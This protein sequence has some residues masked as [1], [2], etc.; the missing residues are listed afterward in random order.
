MILADKFRQLLR[1]GELAYRT[2]GP[3]R[4]AEKKFRRSKL[5]NLNRSHRMV[6]DDE[7]ATL[8]HR[9]AMLDPASLLG[10]LNYARPPFDHL[11]VEYNRVARIREE[12]TVR[13][14]A[15]FIEPDTMYGGQWRLS[16]VVEAE[17]NSGR[18]MLMP[19]GFVVDFS[20]ADFIDGSTFEKLSYDHLSGNFMRSDMDDPENFMK[21]T[22]TV[23]G[24]SKGYIQ[25]WGK[26]EGKIGRNRAQLLARYTAP[27]IADE[28][29]IAMMAEN[30]QKAERLMAVGLDEVAGEVRFMIGVLALLNVRPEK[31]LRIQRSGPQQRFYMKGG[32][33]PAYEFREVTLQR[34]STKVMQSVVR[35]GP[36]TVA[37]KRWHTVMGHR[38][39]NRKTDP[40][41][42]HVW[43]RLG[44][45]SDQQ[46]C[47][48]CKGKSWW[49]NAHARGDETLGVIDKDYVIVK[50]TPGKRSTRTHKVVKTV[51]TYKED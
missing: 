37:N 21:L 47:A 35:L 46:L 26:Q 50:S 39:H 20:N 49:K 41:C 13:R 15:M 17:D 40:N 48:R 23:A 33:V 24:I 44:I 43:I 14:S 2:K 4:P 29:L 19:M 31:N 51:E 9:F 3:S 16:V 27:I 8:A 25:H 18:I 11:W 6:L 34:P 10:S 36:V 28:T 12:T 22:G 30:P 1:K 7:F 38:A 42:L 45:G 5:A 32:G